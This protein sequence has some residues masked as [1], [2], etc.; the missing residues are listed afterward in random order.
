APRHHQAL[1]VFKNGIEILPA[2]RL[3]ALGDAGL[4]SV[5]I[6]KQMAQAKNVPG[7]PD[8][9]KSEE[10]DALLDAKMGVRNVFLGERRGTDGNAGQ[11]NALAVADQAAIDHYAAGG[12]AVGTDHAKADSAIGQQYSVA[13]L[14]IPGQFGVGRGGNFRSALHGFGRDGERGAVFEAV[15]AIFKRAETDFWPLQI[16]KNAYMAFE[17]RRQLPY[18]LDAA[19]MIILRAMRSVQ[20]KDVDASLK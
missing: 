19:R 18:G 10:V 15:R 2:V 3:C 14:H 5:H 17:L 13:G 7:L 1:G 6:F 12:N 20:S 8:E 9:G 16:E 11:V 4:W